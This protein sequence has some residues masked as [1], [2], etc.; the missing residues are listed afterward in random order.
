MQ[1]FPANSQASRLPKQEPAVSEKPAEK[2]IEAVVTGGVSRRKKPLGKRFA[3][4]FFGENLKNVFKW[5]AEEV[6]LPAAKD[7][8]TDVVS[9]GVERLIYGDARS[10]SRRTGYRPGGSHGPVSYNRFSSSQP[11][12]RREEPRQISYRS[13]ASHDFEEIVLATRHEAE[14]VISRMFDIVA[15]YEQASVSDLYCLVDISPKFTDEK[16][17]WTDLRGAGV[18]RI[19]NGYLLDLPRPEALD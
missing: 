4:T 5:L 17:G 6:L 18:T 15:K 12:F 1:D 10:T 7:T 19:R 14:E 13:R 9:Q 16:W 3:E 8:V 2:K 11:P